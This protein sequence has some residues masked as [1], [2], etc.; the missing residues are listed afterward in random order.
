[1][2]KDYYL[3]LGVGENA[4][5]QQV[6]EEY[7]KLAL[8]YH[9]DRNRDNP[10]AA[11]RMKE[12]NESYA[13]LSNP[14]KRSEYDRLRQLYGSSAYERFKKTHTEQD[15]FRG[16]DIYQVLEEL[17]RAFGFR[18]FEEIFKE[19]YGPGFRTFEFR[20][21]GLPEGYS[22]ADQAPRQAANGR[23]ILKEPPGN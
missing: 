4:T 3:I 21:P 17:S 15:I 19:F 22:R 12:I 18:G 9:P 13:V 5:Q 10:E 8:K 2:E 7:R 16:S 6:K 1:M 11:G 20:G 14:Q 23:S